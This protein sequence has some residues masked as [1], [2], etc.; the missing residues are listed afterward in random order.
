LLTNL[1]AVRDHGDQGEERRGIGK[2]RRAK[3]AT[4]IV[5]MAL[6]FLATCRHFLVSSGATKGVYELR[7]L[8][9]TVIYRA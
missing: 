8:L 5:G 3:R 2:S 7:W 4:Q 1:A 6:A 9:E